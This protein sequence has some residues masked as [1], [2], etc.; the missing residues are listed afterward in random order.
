MIDFAKLVKQ[1]RSS[2]KLTQR[3]LAEM[4]GITERTIHKIENG[5]GSVTLATMEKLCETLGLDISVKPKKV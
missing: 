5:I 4:S 2:L 3:D 1:R